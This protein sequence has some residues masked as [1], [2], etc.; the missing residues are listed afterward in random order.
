MNEIRAIAQDRDKV[1]IAEQAKEAA[2]EA[3]V[4]VVAAEVD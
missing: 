4:K 1:I 2:I 3:P